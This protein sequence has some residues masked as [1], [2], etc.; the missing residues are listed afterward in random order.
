M[1]TSSSSR[2]PTTRS[3]PLR[4]SCRGAKSAV[5]CSGAAELSVLEFPR[6]EGAQVGG[7]H[8]LQ[9]FADPE[10]AARGLKGCAIAVEAEEP[11]ATILLRIVADLGARALRVPA[12]AR[13]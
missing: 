10:V 13:A 9:M 1:R 5:H 4:A 8:P 7:F 6:Q 2:C 12:G 3:R 11:L